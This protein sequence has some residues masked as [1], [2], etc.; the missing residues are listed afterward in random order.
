MD[1]NRMILSGCLKFIS[2][3]KN[4]YLRHHVH[5]LLKEK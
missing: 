1:A 4:D 2:G 3:A 5:F